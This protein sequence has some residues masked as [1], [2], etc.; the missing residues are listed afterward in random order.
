MPNSNLDEQQR[1][2][3]ARIKALVAQAKRDGITPTKLAKEAGMAPS[4]LNRKLSGADKSLI[5]P[6][7]LAMLEEAA[8][9]LTGRPVKSREAFMAEL[10]ATNHSIAHSVDDLVRALIKRGILREE[11]LP[12]TLRKSIERRRHLLELLEISDT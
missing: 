6:A 1:R 10:D 8:A 2:A 11:D 5:K 7:T 12:P 9:R 4:T 3:L